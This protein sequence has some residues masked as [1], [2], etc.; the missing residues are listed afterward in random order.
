MANKET[1]ENRR[2]ENKGMGIL[3]QE[4]AAPCKIKGEIYDKPIYNTMPR[5]TG[6]SADLFNLARTNVET[7]GVCNEW[8]KYYE[9]VNTLNFFFS[10]GFITSIIVKCDVMSLRWDVG[11]PE[12]WKLKSS[13]ISTIGIQMEFLILRSFVAPLFSF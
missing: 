11:V 3:Y 4:V 9:Q 8:S 6:E 10:Y 2:R 1:E 12:G 5:D 13:D 7:I